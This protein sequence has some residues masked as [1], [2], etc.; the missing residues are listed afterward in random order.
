MSAPASRWGVETGRL[1][2]IAAPLFYLSISALFY[3]SHWIVPVQELLRACMSFLWLAGPA[4]TLV[5]AH[6]GA[7]PMYLA[8]TLFV[9]GSF[10]GLRLSHTRF[11]KM[12][13]RVAGIVLW[14]AFG[15][16][17]YGGAY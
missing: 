4:A 5:F 13:F 2:W 17:V 12:A 11:W 15:A 1:P 6:E 9:L 14:C 10:V 3:L 7:F 8:G 16:L